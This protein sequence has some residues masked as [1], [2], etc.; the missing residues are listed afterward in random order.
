[1]AISVLNL[2]DF[3][4][5]FIGKN[6]NRVDVA[7][8]INGEPVYA[9]DLEMKNMLFAG[10]FRSSEAHA[11]LISIDISRALN[12][13]GVVTILTHKDIPGINSFGTIIKDQP[14]LAEKKVRFYGEP[15]ALIVADSEDAVAE[16]KRKIIVHY[17]RLPTVLTPE[18]ALLEDTVK[19]H[20]KGNILAVKKVIKGNIEEAMKQS[21]VVMENE[22]E[23][24]FLDH[25]FLETESG[26][27]YYDEKTDTLTLYSSTQNIHYKRKEISRMLNIGEDKIKVVQSVTGGGFGGK[28]DVTV[29]GWISLAV[30]HTKKPVKI[31]LSRDESLLTNT[32][33]HA[34]KF[35]YTTAA[36]KHGNITGVKVKIIGDTGAYASYGSTVC[37]RSAVHCTGPY[38][39]PNVFAES[40]MLYTNN[41]PCGAMRGFG[42]PQT[43][44]AHESQM[45]EIANALNIDPFE[46]R[47]RNALQQGDTTAT[48]QVL[49]HSVGI[50]ETLNKL[51]PIYKKL[52][53][54]NAKGVGV[55]CMFYGIGNT[56]IPNP[57]TVEV[58]LVKNGTILVRSGVCEIGQGSDTVLLQIA[59]E[60]LNIPKEHVTFTWKDTSLTFDAGSTSAS[61]Q[62]YISGKALFQACEKMKNFLYSQGFYNGEA[63]LSQIYEKHG[64][65]KFK[66]VFDPPT[67]PLDSETSQGKP[68]A[69]YA[70]ATHIAYLKTDVVTGVTDVKKV[71]AAH[72]VGKAVNPVLLQGQVNSG[73]AMG[74]GMALMENFINGKT[75]NI[76]NY[77]IPTSVDMPEVECYFT[78][79][80]EPTGPYGA[81]GIGEP[82]LIPSIPAIVNAIKDY[83]GVRIYKLPATP[84]R[85]KEELLKNNDERLKNGRR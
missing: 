64:K 63:T 85:V 50:V 77:Y 47:L 41:H 7:A 36:D 10:V 28:L 18:Q 45:D 35:K 79:N 1:M 40:I 71:W 84:E 15:V 16:A 68:Y 25:M 61:R 60:T 27:G 43:S 4:V 24:S 9:C 74:V 26:L 33:R 2:G 75:L 46:L 76:D 55:G 49:H 21:Y 42:I 73:V 19:I 32:K 39:I 48:G 20:E 13:A 12:V 31:S 44:F 38:K 30:F 83:T 5:K 58:E 62:T 82:A 81:K 53:K 8:K 70:F 51:K 54:E 17:N 34:L 11:E 56:G 14:F 57:A 6:F 65:V 22:Y 78:E 23:T 52:K 67:T 69:T 80:E 3:Q 72:D 29:E 59:L 37:L 66:G